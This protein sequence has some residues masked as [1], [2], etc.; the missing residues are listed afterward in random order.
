MWDRV[1]NDR[2]STQ[3]LR[4]MNEKGVVVWDRVRNDRESTQRL[5]WND[6]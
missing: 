4:W 5:R 1:R 6:E 3:R 2:E